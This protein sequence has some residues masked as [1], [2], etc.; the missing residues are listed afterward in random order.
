[1]TLFSAKDFSD[2]EQVVFAHDADTGLKAIIAIHSTRRGPALGGCRMWAY[3]SE[4]EAVTDVLR[5]SKGMTY[6]A[7]LADLPL[8]GGKSVIIGDSRKDKTPALMK[9]MGVAVERLNGRYVVAEDVGTSTADMTFIRET[10]RHAVGLAPDTGG[11]GDPSPATAWGV[12]L[13]LK[14]AVKHQLKTDTLKG[15]R[16]A[17]QGLG[18]VGQHLCRHLHEAGAGLIVADIRPDSVSRMVEL[19]GAEMAAPEDIHA[20]AAE[21]YAPCALGA[22]LNDRSIPQLQCKIVAGCANNQLA[23]AKHGQ[24]LLERGILYCPDYVINAGGLI[25]VGHEYIHGSGKYDPARAYA[26]IARIPETLQVIFDMSGKDSLPTSLAADRLA[27]E[28]LS[29]PQQPGSQAA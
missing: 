6:K 12:F 2:H 10:T 17:V 7:A 21:V 20:A 3:A 4:A 8:G 18:N 27:G 19:F 28:K 13:G 22:T 26:H 24:S 14:Q 16:V 15:L 5:L 29:P 9:A 11:S 25:N 1:M 23:E